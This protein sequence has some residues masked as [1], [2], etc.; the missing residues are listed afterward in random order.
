MEDLVHAPKVRA[1]TLPGATHFVHLD[2]EAHGR[3]MLLDEITSFLSKI[4][5]ARIMPIM[6]QSLLAPS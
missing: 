4:N 1:V 2:R 5:D 3:K 6:P